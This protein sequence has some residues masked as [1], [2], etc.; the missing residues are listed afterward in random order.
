LQSPYSQNTFAGVIHQKLTST[1][2]MAKKAKYTTRKK[3]S[4]PKEEESLEEL[5][6]KI[7]H[8][9]DALNKIIKKYSNKE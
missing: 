2:K 1:G 5:K 3:K 9:K 7:K 8:Q 4:E 6:A